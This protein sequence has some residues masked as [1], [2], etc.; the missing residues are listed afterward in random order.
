VAVAEL[1]TVLLKV[2]AALAAV[3]TAG[4]TIQRALQIRAVVVVVDTT[5]DNPH[6]QAAL[7]LSLLLTHLL[8]LISHQLVVD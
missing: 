5:R 2:L 1:R 8:M 7:A 3:V 6:Q 4:I